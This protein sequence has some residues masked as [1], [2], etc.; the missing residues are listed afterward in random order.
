MTEHLPLGYYIGRKADTGG[1]VREQIVYITS[2]VAPILKGDPD[3]ERLW[4]ADYGLQSTHE[5]TLNRDEIRELTDIEKLLVLRCEWT[6]LPQ[7]FFQ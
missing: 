3:G 7:G 6:E 1:R 2:E 4:F 5:A